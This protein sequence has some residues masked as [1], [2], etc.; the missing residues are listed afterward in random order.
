[1]LI[2][3]ALILAVATLTGCGSN[4]HRDPDPGGRILD[5]LTPIAARL[6][7]DAHVLNRS[8]SE[9]SWGSC[10]GERPK[11]AGWNP[12]IVDI[13]FTTSEDGASMVMATDQ[14]MKAEGWTDDIDLTG[15]VGPGQ[16][17]TRTVATNI[18]A[19]AALSPVL[20]ADRLQ[21]NLRAWAYPPGPQQSGC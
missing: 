13:V 16:R 4:L 20:I 11:T 18:Q 5:A 3:I 1:V 21:W 6:P 17:W 7:A 12:I 14:A 8:V 9:G 19:L 10:D 2:A 15:P